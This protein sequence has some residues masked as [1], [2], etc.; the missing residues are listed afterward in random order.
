MFAADIFLGLHATM[1]FVYGAIAIMVLLGMWLRHRQTITWTAATATTG[2][3]I[4]F[5]ISNFG[6]WLTL[7][8]LYSRTAEGLLSA[9]IAAIPFYQNALAGT[10]LFTALLFG[11][12]YALERSFPRLAEPAAG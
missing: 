5:I 9:Y 10:L 2:S 3:L 12:F 8:E 7:P 4:F 11:G 6:A 1:P